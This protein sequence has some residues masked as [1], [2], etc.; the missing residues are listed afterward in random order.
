MHKTYDDLRPTNDTQCPTACNECG[1]MKV[2]AGLSVFNRSL[3]YIKMQNLFKP[4]HSVLL[5]FSQVWPKSTLG[6][7]LAN[8]GHEIA[9]TFK[10]IGL[11]SLHLH[12]LFCRKDYVLQKMY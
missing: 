1:N 10:L 12:E 11:D 7:F 8:Y 2:S 4:D 5:K 3:R 9:L 6:F